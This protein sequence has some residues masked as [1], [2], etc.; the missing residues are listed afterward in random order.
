MQ[1]VCPRCHIQ[2]RSTDYYCFNCGK[3]LK[4]APPKT[5]ITSQIFLYLKSFIL[6]PLGLWWALPYL[7]QKEFKF[8]LI[9]VIAIILTLLSV[10]LAIKLAQDFSNILNEQINQSLKSYGY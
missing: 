2:V 3:N 9:G 7:K 5:D 10:V 6:P 1:S 8:K 4:P